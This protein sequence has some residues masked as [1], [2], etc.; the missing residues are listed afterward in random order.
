MRRREQFEIKAKLEGLR[1]GRHVNANMYSF[2]ET[3]I[4]LRFFNEGI[5]VAVPEKCLPIL[6]MEIQTLMADNADPIAIYSKIRERLL[7]ENV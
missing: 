7:N 6:Q 2:K 3:R 1:L 4:A 5:K